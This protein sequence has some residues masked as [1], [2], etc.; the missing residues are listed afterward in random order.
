MKKCVYFFYPRYE[1][2]VG[3]YGFRELLTRGAVDIVQPDIVW[4][5]GFTECGRIAALVHANNIM[6][7]PHAFASA[8]LLVASIPNGII[9]EFDHNPH[10]LRK[11]L[12]KEAISADQEGFVKLPER[13]G[14][15]VELDPVARGALP[16]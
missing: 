4:A 7:A 9:L 6:V 3:R 8:I 1:T 5:G 16:F 14:R 10:A 11:E 13:P 15:G 2:E 12:L